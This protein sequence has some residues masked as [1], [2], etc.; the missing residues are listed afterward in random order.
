MALLVG[1][2]TGKFELLDGYSLEIEIDSLSISDFRL[3]FDSESV[4]RRHRNMP[5]LGDAGI[6]MTKGSYRWYWCGYAVNVEKKM[7][8]IDGCAEKDYR[9]PKSNLQLAER[10]QGMY[11]LE[12]QLQLH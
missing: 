4:T 7:K 11:G 3:A 9:N 6:Q 1:K 2:A 5:G 12:L 10:L 8:M